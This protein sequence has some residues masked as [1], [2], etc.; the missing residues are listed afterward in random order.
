MP[1]H[2][3]GMG[4]KAPGAASGEEHPYAESCDLSKHVYFL[5]FFI[6]IRSLETKHSGAIYNNPFSKF[7][8]FFSLVL[9]Q[10][11]FGYFS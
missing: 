7:V 4:G 2:G 1:R 6:C 5:A 8:Q 9:Y 3:D 10:E 11:I